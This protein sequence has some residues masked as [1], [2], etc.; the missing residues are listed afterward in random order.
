M[1]P[2]DCVYPPLFE[3]DA[4]LL[5]ELFE[6]IL[7]KSGSVDSLWVVLLTILNALFLEVW[8]TKK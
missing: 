4:G 2:R 7:K 8:S 1:Y 5:Y 6:F 3:T